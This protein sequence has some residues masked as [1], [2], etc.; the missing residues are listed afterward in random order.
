MEV[1]Y[2]H[3]KERFQ[4]WKWLQELS[5]SDIEKERQERVSNYNLLRKFFTCGIKGEKPPGIKKQLRSRPLTIKVLEIELHARD[6]TKSKA[7]IN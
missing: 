7:T 4:G 2:A 1:K 5:Y 3:V 6:Q